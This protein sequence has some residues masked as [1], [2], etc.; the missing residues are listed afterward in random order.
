MK[1]NY[2]SSSNFSGC[3][4]WSIRYPLVS[5]KFSGGHQNFIAFFCSIGFLPCHM[6]RY[7]N[8]VV[9]NAAQALSCKAVW[10]ILFLPPF[11]S[12]LDNKVSSPPPPPTQKKKLNHILSEIAY[13]YPYRISFQNLKNKIKWFLGEVMT[14]W[15]RVCL[16]TTFCF[17]FSKICIWVFWEL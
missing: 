4:G 11:Y 8:F 1:R 9:Y 12:L 16:V 5:F 17:L 15:Y 13:T 3:L 6:C 2:T 7:V 10:L 14:K